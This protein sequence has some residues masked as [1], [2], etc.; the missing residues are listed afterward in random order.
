VKDYYIT[1]IDVYIHFLFELTEE[2]VYAM[3]ETLKSRANAMQ[4]FYLHWPNGECTKEI[5]HR[6]L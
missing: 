2:V 1:K 3:R 6:L 4:A 5:P